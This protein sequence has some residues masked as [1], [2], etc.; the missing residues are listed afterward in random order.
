MKDNKIRYFIHNDEKNSS[1]SGYKIEIIDE[2]N[3]KVD[4][5][6]YDIEDFGDN[7]I[8]YNINYDTNVEYEESIDDFIAA[9][10]LDCDESY[11]EI[12]KEEY[13]KVEQVFKTLSYTYNH[14][15][16]KKKS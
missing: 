2:E 6:I 13:E 3:I 16:C 5:L 4:E 9:N 10:C 8:S 12:T 11:K 1:F 14:L 7:Q 15:F